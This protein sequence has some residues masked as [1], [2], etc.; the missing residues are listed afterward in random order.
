MDYYIYATDHAI[1]RY[2]QRQKAI[3]RQKAIHNI[4]EG[5][6]RSRLIGFAKGKREIR[7]HRGVIFVCELEGET[8]NVITILNSK[9]ELRFIG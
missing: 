2:Q 3:S 4:V 9:A 6:K 8:M 5:V 1:E 7:E